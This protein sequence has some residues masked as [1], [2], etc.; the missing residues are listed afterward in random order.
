MTIDT[1]ALNGMNTT[2]RINYVRELALELFEGNHDSAERWLNSPNIALN[3]TTPIDFSKSLSGT[4]E[5]IMFIG[6]LEHG[7][8]S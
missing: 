8:F 6:R 7:V 5:V 4:K 2:E 1:Q 3:H